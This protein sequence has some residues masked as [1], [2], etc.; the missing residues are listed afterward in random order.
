MEKISDQEIVSFQDR[1]NQ[2]MTTA[3]DVDFLQRMIEQIIR[4]ATGN[5]QG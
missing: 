1:V 3:S 2:G 4:E 5:D